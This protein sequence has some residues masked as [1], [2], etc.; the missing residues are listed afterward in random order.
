MFTIF[1]GSLTQELVGG[2]LFYF[3]RSLDFFSQSTYYTFLE[4]TTIE[5]SEFHRFQFFFRTLVYFTDQNRKWP[6]ITKF[7]IFQQPQIL[8]TWNLAQICTIINSTT[9]QNFISLM[10][11]C[12]I[13]QTKNDFHVLVCKIANFQPILPKFFFWEKLVNG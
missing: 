4:R 2:N 12:G 11:M 6:K 7:A 1:E 9:V 13:L 5:E 3:L 8:T 10:W